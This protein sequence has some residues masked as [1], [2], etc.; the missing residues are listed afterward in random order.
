MSAIS[1]LALWHSFTTFCLNKHGYTSIRV[2]ALLSSVGHYQPVRDLKHCIE[3]G[4]LN[5]K[6]SCVKLSS[7]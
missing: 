3:T 1:G 6:A 2:N 5:V 7:G 4:I